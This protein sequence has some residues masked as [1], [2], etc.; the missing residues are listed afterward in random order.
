MSAVDYSLRLFFE[1]GGGCLWPGGESA[2]REFGLGPYDLADPCPLPL[3]PRLLERCR[4]MAAGHDQSLNQGYPP[5][6]GPWR[7]HE[8]D[9]FNRA[10]QVLLADIRRELGSAF[11]LVDQ[12]A[13]AAEDPDLDTNLQDPRAFRRRT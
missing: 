9:E 10:T 7:Q 8:C 4:E 13:P 11:E 6:P 3:S 12:Q 5:D 1:W 2:R